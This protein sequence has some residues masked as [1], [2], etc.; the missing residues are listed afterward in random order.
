MFDGRTFRRTSA[1]G[2]ILE[3]LNLFDAGP[4]KK[5][6]PRRTDTYSHTAATW[7]HRRASPSEVAKHTVFKGHTPARE[8]SDLSGALVCRRELYVG[9]RRCGDGHTEVNA[10]R[11]ERKTEKKAQLTIAASLLWNFRSQKKGMKESSP[12]P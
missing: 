3:I 8:H 1:N 10:R 4:G 9:A 5:I 2:K 11:A 12:L 7:A 6:C